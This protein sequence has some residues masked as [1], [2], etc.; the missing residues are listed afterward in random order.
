MTNELDRAAGR[1]AAITVGWL[2]L[3]AILAGFGIS[4]VTHALQAANVQVPGWTFGSNSA[5]IAHFAGVPALLAAGWA[6]LA[7]RQIYSRRWLVGSAIAGAFGF[8]IAVVTVMITTAGF[9][10]QTAWVLG[11]VWAMVSGLWVADMFNEVKQPG[12]LTALAIDVWIALV[13]LLIFKDILPFVFPVM[14]GLL[15]TMPL[16]MAAEHKISH[17]VKELSGLPWMGVGVFGLPVVLGAMLH[18]MNSIIPW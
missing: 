13:A 9:D 1:R 2:M 4:L 16:L 12:V 5:L 15:I 17:S 10:T 3:F 14:V 6:A 7:L 11:A 18:L 8:A